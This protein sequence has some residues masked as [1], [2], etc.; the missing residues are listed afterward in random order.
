M[1]IQLSWVANKTCVI[2][3]IIYEAG[4]RVDDWNTFMKIHVE[5]RGVALDNQNMKRT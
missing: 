5:C 1:S 3:I 4:R 2:I